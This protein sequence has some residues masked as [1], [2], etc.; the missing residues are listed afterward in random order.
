MH[1]SMAQVQVAPVQARE[2]VQALLPA[3]A[4]LVAPLV[5]AEAARE[6]AQ[7]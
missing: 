3:G 1:D 5:W 4:A 2:A 7:A 6:A